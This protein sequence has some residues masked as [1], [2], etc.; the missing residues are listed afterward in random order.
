MVVPYGTDA[1]GYRP[2][3]VKSYGFF[4]AIIPAASI[5]SMH[6]DAEFIPTDAIGPAIEIYFEAVR[7]T[8]ARR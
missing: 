4:P 5:L 6:G 1:N 8:A 2:K 3:G 7:E